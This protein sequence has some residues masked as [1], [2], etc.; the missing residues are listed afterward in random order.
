MT[1]ASLGARNY[2]ATSGTLDLTGLPGS[3]DPAVNE[4]SP[5]VAQIT[6]DSG[7]GL[8]FTRTTPTDVFDAQISL[9]I[10]VLD[11]DS[12]AAV[13]NPVTFGAGSG[14]VFNS[15]TEFRYGRARFVN[16]VGSELVNLPV[17]LFS[18]YFVDAATGFIRNADDSCSTGI[19]I[20]FNTFTEDLGPGETCVLDSGSPGAS[21]AGCAV[22]AAPADQFTQPPVAG[23]FNLILA[24]PGAGNSGSV[25][26]GAGVPAWL[27]F[28]WDAGTA[29]DEN[30]TAQATFGLF[31]GQP[32]QI[33][34]REL[35][36]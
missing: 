17:G 19:S 13:G 6:F 32:Q 27:Q 25:T 22:A 7:A 10:D 28:D 26:L 24:A 30:P 15:G 12:R 29:G 11:G 14:I 35:F 4:D 21:G 18:E 23:S 34:I 9:A 3:G 20:S 16:A 33:Y 8:A 31:G 2:A 5:G 36:N 1:T